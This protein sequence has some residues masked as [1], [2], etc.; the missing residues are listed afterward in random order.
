MRASAKAGP[1]SR[2]RSDL[3]YRRRQPPPVAILLKLYGNDCPVP[4]RALMVDALCAVGVL[5]LAPGESRD[6]LELALV[7]AGT[8]LTLDHLSDLLEVS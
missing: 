1:L 3:A 2:R 6:V 4:A 5:P 8:V 7:A